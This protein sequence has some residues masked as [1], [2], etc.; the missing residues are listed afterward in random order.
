M[1]TLGSGIWWDLP[2]KAQAGSSHFPPGKLHQ[3]IAKQNGQEP[4]NHQMLFILYRS[5]E[6]DRAGQMG[7]EGDVP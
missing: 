5:S 3:H 2:I 7:A 4:K 1:E 6:N